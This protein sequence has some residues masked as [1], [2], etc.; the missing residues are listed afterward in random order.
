MPHIDE[1]LNI[2]RYRATDPFGMGCPF[3]ALN[4]EPGILGDRLER[5][6]LWQEWPDRDSP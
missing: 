3:E 5:G 4:K 2:L 1:P 6:W